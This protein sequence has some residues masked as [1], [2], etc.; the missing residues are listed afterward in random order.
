MYQEKSRIMN[1]KLYKRHGIL[2]HDWRKAH[3]PLHASRLPRVWSLVI[4]G[5]LVPPASIS[6]AATRPVPVPL[7]SVAVLTCPRTKS[8]YYTVGRIHAVVL[9]PTEYK[10][11]LTVTHTGHTVILL[12]VRQDQ[13]RIN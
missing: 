6:R 9:Y 2:M 10:L 1:R 12:G 5:D 11:I 3:W 7:L 13:L 8:W 4:G